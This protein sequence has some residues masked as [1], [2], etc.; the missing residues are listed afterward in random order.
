M[1]RKYIIGFV[2]VLGMV[3]SAGLQA[4]DVPKWSK[5]CVNDK[6]PKT[7]RIIQLHYLNKMVDGKKQTLGKVLGL[8]V[9]YVENA[10]TKKRQP[11]ISVQMPLGLDLRVGAVLRIDQGKELQMPF[12]Q[13]TVAGCDGSLPL[14]S[15]LLAAFKAGSMLKVGFR[16]WGTSTVS[17][18]DASLSG[19]TRLFESIR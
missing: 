9:L 16:P 6:N 5:A 2:L 17:A 7:C 10:T 11:V 1:K 15:T 8:T 19:F 14:D 4:Q 3:F 18:V 12:L 13:C